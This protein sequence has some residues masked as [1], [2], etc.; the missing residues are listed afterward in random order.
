VYFF[1]VLVSFSIEGLLFSV[2]SAKG[3]VAYS[4]HTAEHENHPVTAS[5]NGVVPPS[6]SERRF[7]QLPTDWQRSST[8]GYELAFH[9]ST[10]DPGASRAQLLA[11]LGAVLHRTTQQTTIPV[12]VGGGPDALPWTSADL[13]VA[14]GAPLSAVVA[15]AA[16]LLG[17]PAAAAPSPAANIAITFTAGAPAGPGAG[18][19]APAG[20]RDLH[21]FIG[22]GGPCASLEIAYNARLFRPQTIARLVTCLRVLLAAGRA[23]DAAA[24]SRLPVLAPEEAAVIAAAADGG[25]AAVRPTAVHHQFEALARAQPDAVACL[26]RDRTLSYAALEERSN[27]LAQ[28]LRAAGVG[29]GVP[30][31]VC[32]RPSTDV[33]VA[34]LAIFKASGVYLPLDP[35][36][37]EAL[38][39]MMLDEAK[40]RV[41]L[42]ETALAHLTAPDRFAQ[43]CFDR[44]WAAVA[45]QPPA[46]PADGGATLADPAYLIYT[47]GT[48]GR[49]KGVLAT[50]ANL[51]HYIDSARH[52]YGF[53]RDDAFCALARYTFSISLWELLSPL[54]CG[55]SLRLIERDDVLAPDRLA[56]VLEGVTVVH[57][58]PSLL[59]SLFRH[60]R[61]GLGGPRAFAR[62]RHASSGG[63]LVAPHVIEEMKQ[64]FP[65]AELFVIYGCTEI[66]CMGTTYPISRA[67]PVTRSF[68][69]RPFPGV[70]ARVLDPQRN[71][72]PFGVTG[73]ICFAGPGVVPG[74]LGR[75]ELTAEKFVDIDGHRFYTTGDLGRV[76]P[77]GHIE[78]LGRRDFQVQVRGI[79]VELPGIENTIRELGLATQCAVV[80]RKTDE[81]EIRLVAFVVGARDADAG[82]LRRALAAR[83]PDY[84]LPNTVVAIEGLPLTANGKLDRNRLQAMAAAPAAPAERPGGGATAAADE[85]GQRSIER[86]I[87]AEVAATLGV[88]SVGL[89]DDFF[90]RGGDSLLAVT[91]IQRLQNMLGLSVP[92]AMLFEHPTVRGLAAHLE[93]KLSTEPRPIPL[94][95]GGGAPPLHLLLGVHV[96]R[97][98]ARRLEGKYACY[99]VYAARELA[100]FESSDNPPGVADLAR[101]YIEIIRRQQPHGPYRLV[102]L[103]FGGIV[104]F[105][106]A[107][108][109]RAAGEAI[110]FLGLLDA[111]LPERGFDRA[112][113]LAALPQRDILRTVWSRLRN[114]TPAIGSPQPLADLGAGGGGGAAAGNGNGGDRRP[115]PLDDVRQRCYRRAATEYLGRLRP[116]SGNVTLI[117]AGRRLQQD[118]SRSPS[119][120]WDPWVKDLAVHTLDAE[121]LALLDEPRVGE[122][123]DIFLRALRRGDAT[124]T[125]HRPTPL[126]L[127]ART[128]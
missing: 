42:T 112:L 91:L 2:F 48:T 6:E 109:L 117:V 5:P 36:H 97:N 26:F 41:V 51:A 57:A 23:D 92:P 89:D 1:C 71:L 116:I 61:T 12:D 80:A 98:L 73:E 21:L 93:G 128:T 99:G 102:G 100:M 19:P 3:G 96:Y 87:A 118:L 11:A 25:R 45:A 31:A 62:M 82:K 17:A 60:L 30:V 66:S 33:P 88:A 39:A 67:A 59:G 69:G 114:Y 15:Q 85:A 83:L 35:T 7:V 101:E 18:D 52:M 53:R 115:N 104:A 74:Y 122:V 120:G 10:L 108:Q 22:G 119:C 13:A 32:L 90:E 14:S 77:D 107:Q 76:H 4:S 78:I 68:V 124:A 40:P 64:V 58:G 123:A 111:A 84:M 86:Q 24:V 65:N 125:D 46:A 34:L 9:R 113:R 105:E 56:R 127:R 103:S 121:H 44:D 126:A 49:P 79:R 70:M 81:G 55:A 63:D 106:V 72:I 94:N 8:V 110:H 27:R 20:E 16:A 28:H 37:P 29:P 43:L 47:S 38:L 75:P 50:H 95:E 54:C